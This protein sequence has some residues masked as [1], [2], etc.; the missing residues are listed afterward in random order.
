MNEILPGILEQK[1]SEIEKKLEL[2]SQFSNSVHI[3]LLDGKFTGNTTFVDP[4]PFARW[5]QK[6]QIEL[7]MMVEEPVQYVDI[8]GKSGIKRFLGHVEKM[9]DQY[10]FLQKAKEYGEAGLALDGKTDVNQI[11]VAYTDLDAL[12]I[13]T[14]DA[15]F[16][17]Q[18]YVPEYAD[19]CKVVR[20]KAPD[21]IIEVD[22]GIN[23]ETLVIAKAQSANRFV[24]TSAL[25]T[26]PDPRS[27]YVTLTDL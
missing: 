11:K 15:G 23:K 14:I 22:G 5:A 19:K 7:H 2:V 10:A 24:C 6:L 8:W 1:W 27:M 12:L 18:V 9:S 16:S 17:G 4:A 25:F 26:S 21:L 20:E 13:M 3:D